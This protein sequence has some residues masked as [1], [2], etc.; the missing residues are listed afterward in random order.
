[1]TDNKNEIYVP[2]MQQ[3]TNCF[4]FRPDGTCDCLIDTEF[5]KP[6]PFFTTKEE[7]Q[8]QLQLDMERQ[9]KKASSPF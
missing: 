7:Y 2:C 1:M 9:R 6:C 5:K 4:A 8:K 3:R